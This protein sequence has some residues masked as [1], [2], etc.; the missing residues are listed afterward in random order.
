MTWGKL[1]GQLEPGASLPGEDK[2]IGRW[3][4]RGHPVSSCDVA[5]TT[6]PFPVRPVAT[7][8]PGSCGCPEQGG[9]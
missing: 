2:P 6:T 7:G 1:F 3:V 4:Q 5:A 8:S 9:R